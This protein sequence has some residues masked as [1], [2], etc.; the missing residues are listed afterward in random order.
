MLKVKT[1]TGREWEIFYFARRAEDATRAEKALKSLDATLEV[2][3]FDENGFVLVCS[4]DSR[5]VTIS[6]YK[7]N[8]KR[9]TA[10]ENVLIPPFSA[11]SLSAGEYTFEF[12]NH[13]QFLQWPRP[14]SPD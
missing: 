9:L 12:R 2:T 3:N 6:P 10:P 14:A 13:P 8:F 7:C 4:S 1:D 11:Y 5:T